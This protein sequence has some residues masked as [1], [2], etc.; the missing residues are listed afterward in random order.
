MEDM[1]LYSR[2]FVMRCAVIS[3]FEIV[4][5][6]FSGYFYRKIKIRKNTAIVDVL[7]LVVSVNLQHLCKI[8]MNTW[9]LILSCQSVST[10]TMLCK[11]T[12]GCRCENLELSISCFGYKTVPL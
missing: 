4:P 8:D 9:N 5:S 12:T 10:Q 1:D 3:T 2:R 11:Y 7:M 6:L